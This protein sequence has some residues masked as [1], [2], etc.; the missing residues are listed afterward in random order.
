MKLTRYTD[1]SLRVLL[2]LASH[3][4]KLCSI[5]EISRAYGISESHVMKVVHDLGKGGFIS[6][7]RGR[8]GGL[9]LGRPAREIGIGEVVRYTEG[10]LDLVDCDG[11]VIAPVCELTRLLD[12]ATAA[13]LS[14][15]DTRSLAD[16]VPNPQALRRL[17]LAPIGLSDDGSGPIRA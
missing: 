4:D 11:C 5:A 3:E 13:F 17:F 9:R 7:S 12:G 6:T 16:L 8:G 14:I 10:D 1:Y 2:H 15:L